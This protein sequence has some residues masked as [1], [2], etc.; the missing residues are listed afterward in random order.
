M[1]LSRRFS[2]LLTLARPPAGGQSRISSQIPAFAVVGMIGFVVDAGVT[3]ACAR[4]LGLWPEV[5]RLPGVVIATI[6]NFF[7]NRAVTFRGSDAPLLRAFLRYC[8]VASG[9][10]AVSYAV[11]SVCVQ[12]APLFGVAVTPGILPLF[13][14]AGV[15][16]AMIVTFLGFRFF[17]FR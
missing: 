1:T 11:Y 15:G 13:T 7:L 17:A 6:V 9:G 14:A 10:V 2:D 12:A 4:Y 5:A 8:L 3:Y 16:V